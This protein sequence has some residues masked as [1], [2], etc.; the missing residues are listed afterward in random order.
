MPIYPQLIQQRD[1]I[2]ITTPSGCQ[3]NYRR[4]TTE[5]LVFYLV[6]KFLLPILLLISSGAVA[7]TCEEVFRNPRVEMENKYLK[8]NKFNTTRGLDDYKK[9]FGPYFEAVLENLNFAKDRW[10]DAGAGNALAQREVQIAR[11][12]EIK[13]TPLVAVGV[14]KPKEA[15]IVLPGFIYKS[16]RYI[17]DIPNSE[18][19]KFDLITDL[20]GAFSY[21]E[22]IEAVLRKYFELLTDE[23]DIYITRQYDRI[24]LRNGDYVSLREWLE[25]IPGI[26][27]YPAEG[28][29]SIGVHLKRAYPYKK[30]IIPDLEI[31]EFETLRPPKRTYLEI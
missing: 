26:K 31:I 29:K 11:Y 3:N 18:L 4:N 22:H 16:G 14:E 2:A 23:G 1:Y 27:V 28:P 12:A 24:Q 9:H 30:I 25:T 15:P 8:E 17:E 20:V 6:L 13:G 5:F 7:N 10:L 21:A 19:G